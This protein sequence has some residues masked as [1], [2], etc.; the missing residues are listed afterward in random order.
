MKTEQLIDQF[1]QFIEREQLVVPKQAKPIDLYR[2]FQSLTEL[3][4]ETKRTSKQLQVSLTSF[5]EAF[6]LME[7]QIQA[8]IGMNDTLTAHHQQALRAQ[9]KTQILTLIELRDRMQRN[10]HQAQTLDH[11]TQKQR[12]L[13]LRSLKKRSQGLMQGLQLN[14]DYLDHCLRQK[15]VEKM[16]V[17]GSLFNPNQMKITEVVFNQ[18]PNHLEV[19]EEVVT[20]YQ[21]QERQV[22]RYA[23]VIVNKNEGVL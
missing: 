5:K 13:T 11:L 10:C 22:I 14:L 2:L 12:W 16:L 8:Q 21:T 17:L 4:T 6:T 9:D 23:E 3:K 19:I 1:K 20:G 7:S 18:S 15:G